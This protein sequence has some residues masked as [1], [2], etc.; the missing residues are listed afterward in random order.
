M[1]TKHLI[2]AIMVALL[3]SACGDSAKPVDTDSSQISNEQVAQYTC[4]MHPH[5][6]STDPDGS[7]PIC[8]MDLVP[9]KNDE[10]TDTNLQTATTGGVDS[11]GSSNE[12]LAQYT[13]PMHPHYLSTDPD[14]SCPICGM[15]LVPLKNNANV[16]RDSKTNAAI[17]VSA[18][19]LQTMGVRTSAAEVVEFG[20]TLRAFGTVEANERLENVS[21]SRLEGWIEDLNVRAEGDFVRDGDLL[22][23]VYSPDLIAAQRDYV[24]ALN[25]GNAKRVKSVKQ[26]LLSTGMQDQ[27]LQQLTQ[28]KTVIDKVPVYA[29]TDG[30]VAELNVRDGDYVKPGTTILRLQSYTKVWVIASIPETDL[31]LIN[32][33]ITADL[34]FPSAPKAL[35]SAKVDYVYPTVDPKTRTGRV[36]IE[37]D[38]ADGK[39]LPGAYADITLGFSKRARLAIASEAI[40]RDS[41]GHHVI[42]AL[43]EGRFDTR[44]ITP[45]ISAEGRTEI[46]AGLQAGDLI[47]ASG[48]F[49]LDSEV[50]LR[51]GLSKLSAAAPEQVHVS[52]VKMNMQISTPKKTLAEIQPDTSTL[53]QIDHVVDMALYFHAALVT[54]EAIDP[55]LVDPAIALTDVLTQRYV[56]TELEAILRDSKS[57]L[58]AAQT[59]LNNNALS[60]ELDRL[61]NAMKPWLFKGAPQHYSDNGLR[62]YSELNSGR[63]WLQKGGPVTN[64]Y[65]NAESEIIAWPKS[66]LGSNASNVIPEPMVQN[67][68]DEQESDPHAAHR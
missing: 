11:D 51:E 31:S 3:L 48:Q 14:G 27:A 50:N 23:R 60:T 63:L 7:C 1:K 29:E 67:D 55:K 42:L 45:G 44:M 19:M 56:E 20:R 47:V 15:D 40:L 18:T 9:L 22:Y 43:G 68:S 21:V 30:I 6:L 61:V 62:V 57:A 10:S 12:Q 5:Y 26:R 8:G 64:P 59:S 58:I 39:L 49:M 38:N 65:G 33:G 35:L 37:V 41:R 24:G 34:R 13:C 36:R 53:A 32:L 2:S 16:D 54:R 52:S 25:S 17:T 4:P 46:L 28:R 66:K